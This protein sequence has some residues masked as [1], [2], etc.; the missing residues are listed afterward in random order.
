[1]SDQ[2]YNPASDPAFRSASV[3]DKI[4]YLSAQDPD[5]AKA[6]PLDQAGYINHLM[7]T[8][9]AGS[10]FQAQNTPEHG[11]TSST[12]PNVDEWAKSHPI[13]G[14]V[15]RG[16]DAAGGAVLGAPRAILG[17]LYHSFADP[18]T[19]DE[20]DRS[21]PE[22]IAE[23]LI[24]APQI[25]D[26]IQTYANPKT[27]PSWD[28][29]KSV[30]PEAL[31]QGTGSVAA[32]EMTPKVTG[33]VKGVARTALKP[34]FKINPVE[35]TVKP[36]PISRLVLGNERAN[37]LGEM[38]YPEVA[39]TAETQA[40]GNMVR[41]AQ[42]EMQQDFQNH[43]N[44]VNEA[45]EGMNND[46]QQRAA[47]RDEMYNDLG[48]ARMRRGR[49]QD[50]IDRRSALAAKQA[51]KNLSLPDATPTTP[52]STA[53]PATLP[54]PGSSPTTTTGPSVEFVQ[55]ATKRGALSAP[56]QPAVLPPDA[57]VESEGRPATW[58]NQAVV[59]DATSGGPN[60][61]DAAVQASPSKRNL[62]IPNNNLIADPAARVVPDVGE[63]K[64]AVI[65]FDAGGNPVPPEGGDI[66]PP[67]LPPVP[68]PQGP[69][70]AS[71]PTGSAAQPPPPGSAAPSF[72]PGKMAPN[73]NPFPETPAPI[74]PQEL[75]D[76]TQT[77]RGMGYEG[78]ITNDNLPLLMRRANEIR[79]LQSSGP[80]TTSQ[81]R[82]AH[83]AL[84]EKKGVR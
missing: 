54:A 42:E 61:F 79:S 36:G 25:A 66:A 76:F 1:M 55:K 19:A 20:Q 48:Q 28:Q 8:D 40:A 35:A 21:R 81:I 69:P 32:G 83:R 18:S 63:R 67:T 3:P 52:G 13:A 58:T 50:T 10:Q 31:G 75:A 57:P 15:V 7:G 78:P 34:A 49:E 80:D 70:P 45:R 77:L 38:V 37:A 53:V 43:G 24:G 26:A 44:M 64:G 65:R 56:P 59:Q 5:F 4:S 9:S 72:V 16:L 68:S 60:T 33:V 74:N 82:E 46:V 14:P 51:S 27:R 12:D 71:P 23:R 2:P 22:V 17:H 47:A 73:S 6:H 41:Q 84:L 11:L 29:V 62:G 39:K 30:L